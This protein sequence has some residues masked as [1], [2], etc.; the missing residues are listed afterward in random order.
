MQFSYALIAAAA[1]AVANA[2]II[3]N[4]P[5]SFVGVTAGKAFNI[6]WS[7]A[8]GPV[9]LTLK[10]G[11][12]NALTTVSPIAS[13]LTGTSYAWLIPATLPVGTYALEIED[14]TNVPNYSVRFEITGG[15]A[16]SSSASGSSTST[17]SS[18]SA[19]ASASATTGSNSTITSSSGSSTRT[20][21][22]TSGKHPHKPHKS[23][24]LT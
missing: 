9:D 8:E 5:A 11:E 17:G 14:S 21:S 13:G 6:S 15:P 3:T 16:S 20:G 4:G 1:C 24:M 22:T 12:A 10:T 19:S 18:S 7:G 23:R 2:V